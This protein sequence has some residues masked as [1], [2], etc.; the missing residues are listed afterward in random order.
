MPYVNEIEASQADA[1]LS[2]IYRKIEQKFG[3]LPIIS[4]R[5]GRSRT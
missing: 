3:F 5:S 4:W 1:H 2:E